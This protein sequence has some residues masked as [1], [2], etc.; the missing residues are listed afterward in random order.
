[1]R[2]SKEE[3]F[4]FI[5]KKVEKKTKKK[6]FFPVLSFI[7]VLGCMICIFLFTFQVTTESIED[8]IFWN[9]LGVSENTTAD[10]CAGLVEIDLST[11]LTWFSNVA[12]PQNMNY[13]MGYMTECLSSTRA[14][15]VHYEVYGKENSK[16]L[17]MSI[18][19]KNTGPRDWWCYTGAQELNFDNENASQV[20]GSDV[21]LFKDKNKVIANFF[22][23]DMW[24]TLEMYGFTE[25]E[26]FNV[27]YSILK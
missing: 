6:V 5:L 17:Q 4:N 15:P 27:L 21:I 20:F 14:T 3:N 9:E 23:H 1:M 16:Y 26:F 10:I 22:A 7:T 2:N 13:E 18:G 8:N 11:E 19:K 24:I 25:E 12:L